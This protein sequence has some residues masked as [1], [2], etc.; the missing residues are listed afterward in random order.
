M[1]DLFDKRAAKYSNRPY[2]T[3][4]GELMGLN[5]VRNIFIVQTEEKTKAFLHD[6]EY[7]RSA[8]WR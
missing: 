1:T 3:V 5:Q 7:A 8:I 6:V 2:F 4:A